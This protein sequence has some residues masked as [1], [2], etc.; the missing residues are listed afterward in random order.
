MRE[1]D[2]IFQ[3]LGVPLFLSVRTD[4]NP[5]A[6]RTIFCKNPRRTSIDSSWKSK[7]LANTF[8]L[9][10]DENTYALNGFCLSG[11]RLEPIPDTY[12]KIST[13]RF[14]SGGSPRTA[15][16]SFVVECNSAFKELD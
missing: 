7:S 9:K 12:L 10:F 1:L 4:Q 3:W 13:Y 2:Y 6:V 16:F 11:R 14:K 15:C 5:Q 8:L